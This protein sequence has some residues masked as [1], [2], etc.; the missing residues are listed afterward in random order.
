MQRDR[1]MVR[2]VHA[3]LANDLD[4]PRVLFLIDQW[5]DARLEQSAYAGDAADAA[6][7]SE[8]SEQVAHAIEALLGVRLVP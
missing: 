7:L 6:A 8:S 3:T 4:T 1:A 2:G 5:A